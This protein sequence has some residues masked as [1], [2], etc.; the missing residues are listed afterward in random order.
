MAI[1]S[2]RILQ[3]LLNENSQFL[4][5][6]QV[7]KHVV[8]LNRM[9]EQL[10]L[11]YEWEVVLLNALSKIGNV[12]H[13]KN[14][15][16]S[17]NADIYFEAFDNSNA[18]FV[19]DITAVSDQGLEKSNPFNALSDMLHELVKDH[20]L[21]ANSFDLQVGRHPGLTYKGGPKVKLKLPGRARFSQ[22]IFGDKFSK[23]VFDIHQSPNATHRY[24]VK[25]NDV[26]VVISYIPR[27]KYASGGYASYTEL[28][29][30]TE[31]T[32]YQALESKASQLAGTCFDGPL[33]IFLCDGGSSFFTK[34]STR[35][36]SY[37]TDEI[38]QGF[39]ASHEEINF[40][41]TFR[42]GRQSSLMEFSRQRNP[43]LI[44]IRLYRG[45]KFGGLPFDIWAILKKME[46]VMPTPESDARNA[47]H[48]IKGNKPNAGRSHW[49]GME[50][51][52]GER[53]TKVKISSRA[54]LELLAGEVDQKKFFEHHGFIPSEL[55]STTPINPFRIALS[56]SQLIQG[57]SVERSESDDDDWIAFELKGPDAAISSFMVPSKFKRTGS[58]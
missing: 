57:I 17:R 51:N 12:V 58:K 1:F 20:G 23:F 56:R 9:P 45:L 52:Y 36:L 16:G 11:S 21:R 14:F 24:E 7:K 13:E 42:S 53:V 46:A 28:H 3:R 27:Q 4:P 49:G 18:F 39:L 22:V 30:L 2:R 19:A 29:S 34:E 33:G 31:N 37:S 35:G 26:D 10:T 8:Q 40:I 44:F 32:V 6:G 15:G 5:E 55:N 50:M 25:T 48:F 38:I 47:I 41:I 43:Y 54:L